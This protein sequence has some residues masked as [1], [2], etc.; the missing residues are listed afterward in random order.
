M[1]RSDRVAIVQ[2]VLDLMFTAN[3]VNVEPDAILPYSNGYSCW[4]ILRE[5]LPVGTRPATADE[6]L[7]RIDARARAGLGRG[8]REPT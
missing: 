3:T 4:F 5:T 7:E 8:H 6:I 1:R 2:G